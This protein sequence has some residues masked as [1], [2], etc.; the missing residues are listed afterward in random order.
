MESFV[1][2][3][4]QSV[5]GVPGKTPY[6]S[7]CSLLHVWMQI[8]SP[9]LSQWRRDFA[10]QAEA[11]ERRMRAGVTVNYRLWDLQTQIWTLLR[12]VLDVN[13]WKYLVFLRSIFLL[14]ITGVINLSV[15]KLWATDCKKTLIYLTWHKRCLISQSKKFW[16]KASGVNELIAWNHHDPSIYFPIFLSSLVLA[17]LPSLS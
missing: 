8:F 7:L 11:T 3:C 15:K 13:S 9:Q 16:A 2:V 14:S 4:W 17:Q 12:H 5:M 6:S 1:Y 10:T